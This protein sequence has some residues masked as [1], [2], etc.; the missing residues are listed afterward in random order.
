MRRWLA[1]AA[2][3]STA[4][5]LWADIVTLKDGSV[6]ECKIVKTGVVKDNKGYIVVEDEKKAQREIAQEEI[7][8]IY[9]GET[10]WEARARNLKWYGDQK[11][12]VKETWQGHAS[13]SKQCRQ[14]K[15]D[16]EAA[17]HAAKS[18]ELRKAEAKDDMEAH[19]QMARW[20]ER[21]LNLFDQAAEEYRIVYQF[22]KEKAADKPAE[23]C[24]LGRWCETKSLFAEAEAEYKEALRLDPKSTTAARG[25]EKLNQIRE[26][27]VHPAIF[28]T[29]KEQVLTAVGTFRSKQAGD[30]AYGADVTEA[31][32]QGHRGM[33]GIMGLALVAAW[34]VEG[35][36]RPDATK[37]APRDLERVLDFMLGSQEEKKALRGPDVWGN[38][39]S[40]GFLTRCYRKPAFKARKEMIRAKIESNMAALTR[41]LGPDGGWMYYDFAKSTSASFVGQA[42]INH[43]IDAREAGI[44]IAEQTL[45]R[46]VSHLRSTKQSPGIFMYRTGVRQTVEGSAARAPGCEMALLRAGQGSPADLAA[47]VDNFFK[48][49]HIIEKI[50][51][52]K[53]TH[54]GAGG[55]AP[56]YFLYGHYW[57]ARAV[58]ELDPG[59]QAGYLARMRDLLLRDQDGDGTF[60]DWP[61]TKPCKEYG[62]ALGA[63]S[64]FELGTLKRVEGKTANLGR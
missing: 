23:R 4:T 55:T 20:L 62:S 33:S 43:M 30:G 57:C 32:V 52:K 7:A 44:P 9:P 18:Y 56:Y 54:M 38:V 12:K 51:G 36:D 5:A 64:L 8:A 16:A 17:A 53:G 21:E 58:K 37:A 25:L 22:K 50:K 10:S 40:I 47:A 3:F 2:V 42:A 48:Y 45:Q 27:Q 46:A 6:I 24:N 63:L 41:M 26:V 34:E 29:V 35:I 14:R 15:L 31:G 28:R 61:V 49:R 39:W 13:F 1:T 11:P 59:M 19:D 60:S